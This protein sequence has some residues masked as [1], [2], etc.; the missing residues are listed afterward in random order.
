MVR[1]GGDGLTPSRS[2]GSFDWGQGALSGT[3][4]M[5]QGRAEGIGCLVVTHTRQRRRRS[6]RIRSPILAWNLYAHGAQLFCK[7]ALFGF[8]LHNYAPGSFISKNG[9]YAQRHYHWRLACVCR[10]Q[11]F[12]RAYVR[13][14]Y[15]LESTWHIPRRHRS[16]HRGRRPVNDA[17]LGAKI[18]GT[19][20]RAYK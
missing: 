12:W 20:V 19:E 16:W 15:D 18:Y 10:L 7:L 1:C 2:R 17:Y 4:F 3:I 9:P 8:F 14:R 13:W 6:R 11:H 5:R